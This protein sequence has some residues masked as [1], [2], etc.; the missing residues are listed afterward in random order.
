MRLSLQKQTTQIRML[1]FPFWSVWC[2]YNELFSILSTPRNVLQTVESS[3]D[4]LNLSKRK[5]ATPLWRK[6]N[7]KKALGC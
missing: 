5:A 7:T 6:K 3:I 4:S 1:T 2:K